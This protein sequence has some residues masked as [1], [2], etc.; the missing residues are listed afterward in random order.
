MA[1]HTKS[2]TFE[3]LAEMQHLRAYDNNDRN[4]VFDTGRN[5]TPKAPVSP[6]DVSPA[7]VMP[8][9]ALRDMWSAKYGDTWVYNGADFGDFWAHAHHRLQNAHQ[10]EIH[11]SHA[12][13]IP[14]E[15]C[16]S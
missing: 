1:L 8:L 6:A 13:L 16:K 14:K 4:L 5:P 7:F 2:N 10:L 15:L 11:S 9:E 3:K 12:R